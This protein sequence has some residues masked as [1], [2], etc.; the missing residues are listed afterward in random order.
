[1]TERKPSIGFWLTLVVL[2][3]LVAYPLS[4]GPACWLW[5]RGA[6][7]TGD[8]PY[9]VYSPLFA[10]SYW[11]T[12]FREALYWYVS[13]GVP[14]ENPDVELIFLKAR[15]QWAERYPDLFPEVPP[16]CCSF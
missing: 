13:A 1:M 16:T 9:R 8:W 4:A 14:N 2:I 15:Y 3:G 10:A 7:P 6:L 12:Q 5:V 11:N